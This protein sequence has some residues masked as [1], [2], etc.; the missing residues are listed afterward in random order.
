MPA[1]SYFSSNSFCSSV[2]VSLSLSRFRPIRARRSGGFAPFSLEKP[3]DACYNI[4]NGTNAA[5]GGRE[6]ND[7][8]GSARRECENGIARSG[9]RGADPG[10]SFPAFCGVLALQLL[11]H[12]GRIAGAVSRAAPEDGPVL[13]RRD[14][15]CGGGRPL[16]PFA[17]AAVTSLQRRPAEA[18]AQKAGAWQKNQTKKRVMTPARPVREGRKKWN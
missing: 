8:N 10:R 12:D 2:S 6:K 3:R 17:A 9:D 13:C 16:P 11:S 15:A 7:E 1:S 5:K 18:E 14:R 4:G